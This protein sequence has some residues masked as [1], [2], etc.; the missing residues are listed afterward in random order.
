MRNVLVAALVAL[1]VSLFATPIAIKAFRLKGYGQLIRDDGPTTHQTKR[2]TPTMGGSVII[3]AV[4]VGYL[5]AHLVLRN[6][7]P[8]L[9]GLLVLYLM[10][11]L[12]VVGFLD[13]YIKVS[14]QRSLGLRAK[15]KLAGQSV[16]ALS[17]A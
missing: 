9:S 5:A 12:G 14:K 1:L 11:G 8:T 3:L 10:T 4:L 6:H 15:A 7:A 17:F 13:D 2:G 16:V